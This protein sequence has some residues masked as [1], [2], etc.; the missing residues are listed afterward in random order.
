MFNGLQIGRRGEDVRNL[1]LLVN[2]FFQHLV[3]QL[4]APTRLNEAQQY[5]LIREAHK[6][7]ASADCHFELLFS[8]DRMHFG[9]F[10]YVAF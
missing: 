3:A 4:L 9:L 2:L 6:V 8:L 1:Y 10:L 7:V 5:F